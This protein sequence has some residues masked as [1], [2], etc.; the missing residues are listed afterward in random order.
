MAAK[1]GKVYTT[2]KTV[3]YLNGRSPST[4]INHA[5][6]RLAV[7]VAHEMESEG[8][9]HVEPWIVEAYHKLPKSSQGKPNVDA[10][11]ILRQFAD[12]VGTSLRGAFI[13]IEQIEREQSKE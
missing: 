4:V 5:I 9:E 6:E 12:A 10:Y 7:V 8:E 3:E 13:L 1:N 2:A 11:L